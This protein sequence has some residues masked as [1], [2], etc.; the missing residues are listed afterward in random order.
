MES[1]QGVDLDPTTIEYN[2]KLIEVY[3]IVEDPFDQCI[4]MMDYQPN[5]AT[6]ADIGRDVELA[7]AVLKGTELWE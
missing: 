1:I 6:P 4:K 5:P 7:D 3:R 2:L